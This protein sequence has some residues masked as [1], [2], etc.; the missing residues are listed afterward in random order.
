[1]KYAKTVTNTGEAKCIVDASDN[2]INRQAVYTDDNDIVPD[3][4]LR[5]KSSRCS[6]CPNSGYLFTAIDVP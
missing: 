6:G 3:I 1:M 5:P 4:A 2:G